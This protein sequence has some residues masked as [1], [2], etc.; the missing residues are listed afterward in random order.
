MFL[1]F[2]AGYQILYKTRWSEGISFQSTLVGILLQCIGSGIIFLNISVGITF[3]KTWLGTSLL[4]NILQGLFLTLILN[5]FLERLS[6]R[7]IACYL[8]KSPYPSEKVNGK[9]SRQV[10]LTRQT[11]NWFDNLDWKA[12]LM[13]SKNLQCIY[14]FGNKNNSIIASLTWIRENVFQLVNV[15]IIK[16]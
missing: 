1:I 4:K 14:F 9:P 16:A 6:L 15:K 12:L 11:E 3:Q 10:F 13:K 7:K 2:I 8:W 5:W